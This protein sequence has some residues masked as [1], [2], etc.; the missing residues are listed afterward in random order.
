[1]NYNVVSPIYGEEVF[2]ERFVEPLH[3]Y[4]LQAPRPEDIPYV[5]WLEFSTEI[6][7]VDLLDVTPPV[8]GDVLEVFHLFRRVLVHGMRVKVIAPVAGLILTPVTNSMAPFDPVDCT[9]VSDKTYL[10]GGGVLNETTSLVD[11]S[12]IIDIPDYA[13]LRIDD[14]GTGLDGLELKVTLVV[15]LQFSGS[16]SVSNK[17]R[18]EV[19]L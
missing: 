4:P 9:Y 15:G 7:L 14:L 13:G 18:L 5:R 17:Q 1:M 11:R 16:S 19:I 3:L 8:A 10:P 12:F 6:A 2:A